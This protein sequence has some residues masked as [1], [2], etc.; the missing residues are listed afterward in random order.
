M[1]IHGQDNVTLSLLIVGERP[2]FLPTLSLALSRTSQSF[3][4]VDS[5]ARM[6]MF[7]PVTE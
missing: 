5:S 6:V 7:L 2:L 1:A 3:S 4:L